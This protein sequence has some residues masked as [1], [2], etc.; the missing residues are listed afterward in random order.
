MGQLAEHLPSRQEAAVQQ[1]PGEVI[2]ALGRSRQG[3][4]KFRVIYT[5]SLRP[6]I[7]KIFGFGL[8]DRVPLC[9]L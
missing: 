1:K 8:Q 6:H 9:S 3:D 4:Q 5:M 2:P 7:L